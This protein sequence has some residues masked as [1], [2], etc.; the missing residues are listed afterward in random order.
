MLFICEWDCNIM[1]GF[2]F[3]EILMLKG[4]VFGFL[5]IIVYGFKLFVLIGGILCFI[6]VVILLI[7]LGFCLDWLVW[8]K[9]LLIGFRLLLFRLVLGGGV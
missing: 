3:G 2:N 5:N 4:I 9:M 1:D 7:R 8:R 6:F